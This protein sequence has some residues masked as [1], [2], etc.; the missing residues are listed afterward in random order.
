MF[1]VRCLNFNPIQ[2]VYS[3]SRICIAK[4]EFPFYLVESN[5][6]YNLY[7][8]FITLPVTSHLNLVYNKKVKAFL[9]L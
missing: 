7:V 3:I 9:L 8:Q 2:H 1:V 4:E 5:W 6:N